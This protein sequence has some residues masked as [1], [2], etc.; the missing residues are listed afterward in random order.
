NSSGSGQAAASAGA[1]Q[2]GNSAGTTHGAPSD[3]SAA[4]GTAGLHGSSNGAGRP[5]E[6]TDTRAVV[7]RPVAPPE[8]TR[9]EHPSNGNFDVVIMQSGPR[10]DL[11]DLGG[12][13]T[14][15]P[16]YTVYLRVG[17]QKEWLLEYCVP[18]R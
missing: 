3:A 11:P 7:V 8:V 4:T 9:I 15:N 12:M 16:V 5:G 1:A 6:M 13:L 18:V 2:S 14:G 17:D 10:A